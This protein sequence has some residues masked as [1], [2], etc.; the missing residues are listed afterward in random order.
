M[1]VFYASHVKEFFA[2]DILAI[3]SIITFSVDFIILPAR[4]KLL[5]LTDVMACLIV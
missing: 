4:T 2:I 1:S 5:S 3:I